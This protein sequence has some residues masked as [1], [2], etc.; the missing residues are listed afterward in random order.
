MSNYDYKV[1]KIKEILNEDLSLAWE[2]IC[3]KVGNTGKDFHTVSMHPRKNAKERWF[4]ASSDQNRV[5]IQKA[6]DPSKNSNVKMHYWIR[7]SEFEILAKLYNEYV[8]D[9][10]CNIRYTDSHVSSYIITLIAELL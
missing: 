10:S 5:L 4:N 6:K 7:Q 8:S 1:L 3:K 9:V 2:Q